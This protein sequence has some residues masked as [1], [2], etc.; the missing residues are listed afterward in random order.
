MIVNDVIPLSRKLSIAPLILSVLSSMMRGRI[1]ISRD[2]INADRI[3]DQNTHIY[4]D[5]R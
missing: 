2:S 5:D 3:H 4:I 1:E